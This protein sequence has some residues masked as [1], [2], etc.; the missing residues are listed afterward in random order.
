MLE[1]A[2]S[3]DRLWYSELKSGVIREIDLRDGSSR[4]YAEIDVCSRDDQGLLGIAQHPRHPQVPD[5][6]VYATVKVEGDCRNQL[7]RL[8]SRNGTASVEKVLVDWKYVGEHIGGRV[9]FGPDGHL[10]LSTGSGDDNASVQDP[11]SVHG[12][13]LRM[14]PDGK[15]VPDNPL[16]GL[17]YAYG[18]RNSFGFTWDQR[19]KYLWATDNGTGCN[20]EVNLV[21]PGANLGWGAGAACDDPPVSTPIEATNRDGPSPVMPRFSYSP[22]DGPTG[23]AFCH[24]CGVPSLEGQILYGAW[25]LGE[26]R[27]LRLDQTRTQVLSE[28][29]VYRHRSAEFPLSVEVDASGQ[30]WVSDQVGIYQLIPADRER[31]GPQ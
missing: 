14:T 15:P 26:I 10:Y 27:A 18:V 22:S 9:E 8:V 12:K 16:V 7:L 4:P 30:L 28:T 6:F 31:G 25:R 17:G 1:I 21:W 2:P 23:I 5:L 13:I 24:G 19:T 20:D 11:G 3:G 29:V